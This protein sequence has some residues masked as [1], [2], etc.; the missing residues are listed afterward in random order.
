[1]LDNALSDPRLPQNYILISSYLNLVNTSTHNRFLKI[2]NQALNSSKEDQLFL[3]QKRLF[4]SKL[5]LN[6]AFVENFR[7]R[8]GF[9]FIKQYDLLRFKG[10][11]IIANT[12]IIDSYISTGIYSTNRYDFELYFVDS[13]PL[14]CLFL[15]YMLMLPSSVKEIGHQVPLIQKITNTKTLMRLV[16]TKLAPQHKKIH[17][18]LAGDKSYD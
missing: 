3:L 18:F 7:Q 11:A 9:A 8:T 1:M 15:E 4:Q 10:A 17:R 5:Q 12:F 14:D 6:T 16:N 13:I 2:E